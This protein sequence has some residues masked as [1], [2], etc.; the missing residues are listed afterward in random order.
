MAE[1]GESVPRQKKRLRLTIEVPD[2]WAD[3][4][5]EHAGY[6]SEPDP[7]TAEDRLELVLSE[8]MRAEVGLT[9]VTLPGDKC[10]NDDFQ[11]VAYTGRI[12]AAETVANGGSDP[13]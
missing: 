8:W 1:N 6:Y 5:D 3:D 12:V 11:V 4:L 10:M 9:I 7:P 2:M 13:S